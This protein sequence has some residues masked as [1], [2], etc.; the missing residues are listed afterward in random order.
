[1]KLRKKKRLYL[2][3]IYKYNVEKD[4][5]IIEVSLDSYEEIFNG[6]DASAFKR[7]DL[8]TDLLK[9]IDRAGY[10]I[11]MREKTVIHF[12]IPK[13]KYSSSKEEKCL[14]AVKNNFEMIIHF[15]D[16]ELKRNNQRI[17][18]YLVLGIII[19]VSAYLLP[20]YTNISIYFNI[21]N[22]GLFIGSWVLFWE[23]F[24]LFFFSSNEKRGSK[25]R[26]YRFL[27]SEI[28]FVYL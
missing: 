9:Y 12:R 21:L 6:W 11:P 23:A 24:T 17:L 8:D 25:K 1:M 2:D 16:R 26:Y 15:I 22:E 28:K 4:A 13:E 5:F 10:D 27:A 18:S 20:I 14:I 3:Q 7:R 19:L